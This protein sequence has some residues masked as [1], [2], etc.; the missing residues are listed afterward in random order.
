MNPLS[1]ISSLVSGDSK[2]MNG[3]K[4]AIE[5]A[6]SGKY[7]P[8][9]QGALKLASDYG[10]DETSFRQMEALSNNPKF[11]HA[12]GLVA[13]GAVS[14]LQN[15]FS[16]LSSMYLSKNKSAGFP[17]MG[18]QQHTPAPALKDNFDERMK[19]LVL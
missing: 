8:D 9:L 10:F 3:L 15:M 6:N 13:P 19:K 18:A 11:I 4:Q 16:Q 7:T 12:L 14:S 1:V 2:I 5:I 17:A